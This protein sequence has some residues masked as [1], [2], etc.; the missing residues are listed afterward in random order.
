MVG[1]LLME[2]I[3]GVADKIALKTKNKKQMA[4]FAFTCCF[5]TCSVTF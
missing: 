5:L 4:F 3:Q 2:G 1:I